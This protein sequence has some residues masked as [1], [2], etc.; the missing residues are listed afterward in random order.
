MVK[1]YADG[2]MSVQEALSYG[3]RAG[4]SESKPKETAASSFESNFKKAAEAAAARRPD[5]T[6][7][8][9]AP[10]PTGPVGTGPA[11]S[12]TTQDVRPGGVLDTTSAGIGGTDYRRGGMVKRFAGGGAADLSDPEAAVKSMAYTPGDKNPDGSNKTK[13]QEDSG[14]LA[15]TAR[16]ASSS[17]GIDFSAFAGGSADG[18]TGSGGD[19][20]GGVSGTGGVGGSASAGEGGSAAAGTSGG[21]ADAGDGG[22]TYRRG[23]RVRRFQSGGR[24]MEAAIDTGTSGPGSGYGHR[25]APPSRRY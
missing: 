7:K 6:I 22:G 11:G 9:A 5:T 3:P 25:A 1:K 17:G 23:G 13:E 8:N 18:A 15:R 10:K 20:T 16:A 2:G 4:G 24:V 12:Y 19:S 21:A 14:A